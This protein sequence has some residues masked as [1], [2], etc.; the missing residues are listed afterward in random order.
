MTA[1]PVR[2]SR[3]LPAESLSARH[4]R[5]LVHD[6]LAAAGR[7]EW[8]DDAELAVSEV[9]T[10]AVLHAHTELQVTVVVTADQLRVEVADHNPAMPTQR[11][12][13]QQA[14]TGRGMALVAAVTH[15]HGVT[16]TPDGKVVWFTVGGAVPTD[17][18][19]SA[20]W[21]EPVAQP[22][23]PGRRVVLRG[24]P[25]T[26]WI[27]ARQHHDALLR[28]LALQRAGTSNPGSDLAAADEA[29]RLVAR[30]VD[31]AAAAARLEGAR[32]GAL[33]AGHPTTVDALGAADL[34]LVV[35]DAVAPA[36]AVLQ[37]VL[38]EGEALA[39]QEQLLVRPGLPEVIAVRDWACEQ[40][41]SQLAGGPPA[42][43]PGTDAERFTTDV[44]RDGV[45]DWDPALVR[46]SDRGAVAADDANRIVA[47]SRP[48][49]ETMGWAPEE[50]VGRRVVALVPHR[51]REAHVAGFTRH[52]TTGEAHAL[53]VD[54]VLPVLYRDG[55]EHPCA[56]LIE[57]NRTVAGRA[58]YVAWITPITAD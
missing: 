16:A 39:A 23:Q 43:W 9:V 15:S 40:V 51:F 7:E 36:F 21:E 37:D 4:A 35:P 5:R 19:P 56:F 47:V 11:G 31:V 55:S 20:G 57:A 25:L 1:V 24:M 48:L 29:R 42:A 8:R 34:E 17:A 26:L 50:L 46:D 53:G 58:V 10:N 30:A 2:R 41:I 28:E 27:A 38:D 14:T 45:V 12:Y 49:A 3:L 18:D 6:A 44:L 22:A 54:L 33:P 52:L 32:A 13:G